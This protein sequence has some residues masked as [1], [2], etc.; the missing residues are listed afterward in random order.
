MRVSKGVSQ[1]RPSDSQ[2]S[3]SLG[4]PGSGVKPQNNAERLRDLGSK[5]G[6]F[7]KASLPANNQA[8]VVNRIPKAQLNAHFGT[9]Q[10]RAN[11]VKPIVY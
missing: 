4:D 8:P 9:L 3:G 1:E 10:A 5:I 6:T 7:S 11:E 2:D